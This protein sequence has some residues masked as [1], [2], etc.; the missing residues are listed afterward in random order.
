MP[1]TKIVIFNLHGLF[2]LKKNG[3]S[4]PEK[5]CINPFD[6]FFCNI[7]IFLF[8]NYVNNITAI[9]FRLHK[10]IHKPIVSVAGFFTTLN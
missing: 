4:C 5:I 6:P 1:H 7:H 10:I 9:Q 8:E 3:I 2:I